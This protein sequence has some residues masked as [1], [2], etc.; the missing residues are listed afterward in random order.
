MDGAVA[1]AI[2]LVLTLGVLGYLVWAWLGP[3]RSSD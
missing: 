3:S 2:V 1:G